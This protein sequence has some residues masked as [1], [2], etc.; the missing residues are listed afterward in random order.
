MMF[1]RN[2]F[3]F[4]LTCVCSFK[5]V[6]FFLSFAVC[7]NMVVNMNN[8]ACNAQVYHNV[9]VTASDNCEVA[10]LTQ[11]AGTT[12]GGLFSRGVNSVTYRATDAAGNSATCTFTV[13]VVDNQLPVL[14]KLDGQYFLALPPLCSSLSLPHFKVLFSFFFSFFSF[15]PPVC[16]SIYFHRHT[17]CPNNVS[18]TTQ[19][20]SCVAPYNYANPTLTDNCPNAL[21]FRSSDVQSKQFPPG[22]WI[23]TWL[24][25]DSSY[26]SAQCSFAITV[27]DTTA[28][29]ISKFR[30]SV[31][32][33]CLVRLL[34]V[35][36]QG[37]CLLTDV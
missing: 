17:A 25:L 13:T 31:C 3:D 5:H 18:I 24:S 23:E 33:K 22:E 30:L 37:V 6:F 15:L 8:G 28:P 29:T 4:V 9:S 20:S 36:V 14:S 10:S 12:N 21:S 34:C 27:T 16:L 2:F 11:T 7:T 19:S 32:L 35:Q 26:N 1:P